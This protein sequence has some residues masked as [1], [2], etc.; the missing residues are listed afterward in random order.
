MLRRSI[1]VLLI[2]LVIVSENRYDKEFVSTYT[3][4]FD[5][6]AD[7]VKSYT[8]EWAEQ[9]TE[10][11][12]K[13]IIRI[14]REFSDAAPRAVYYA[15]RRSSWYQNDFQ[16]RRAQAILNAIVGNWDRQGVW[17]RTPASSWG[18]TYSFPGM[19]QQHCALMRLTK[20]F[21]WQRRGMAPT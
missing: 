21:P 5:P 18:S 19:I 9:E 1:L 16:M 17:C 2:P 10:I 7:H 6:L 12:A 13:E 4:G 20:T 14:A 8:P 3:T 11:P 15:G